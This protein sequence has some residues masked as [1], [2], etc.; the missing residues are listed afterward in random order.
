MRSI[1]TT[2]ALATF[3]FAFPQIAAAE[4]DT[5][6]VIYKSPDIVVDKIDIGG[7]EIR[8]RWTI[9]TGPGGHAGTLKEAKRAAR[10]A[11]RALKKAKKQA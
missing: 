5:R 6:E 4:N 2:F 10:K 9:E 8:Y 3:C 1:I 11:L 7:G